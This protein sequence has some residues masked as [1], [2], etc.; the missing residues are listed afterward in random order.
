MTT[1]SGP[2]NGLGQLHGIL[3][4]LAASLTFS[5]LDMQAKYLTQTQSVVQISWARYFGHFVVMMVF[6]WPKYG[7]RLLVTKRPVMQF[8]R[9]ILLLLCT[10]M[11]F[12][13]VSLM[14]LADAVAI[15]FASPMLAT[16]LSVPLLKE[17]VG[18]RRWIA[19]LVGFIAVLIIIRPGSGVMSWA[20]LLVIGVAFFFSLF[21]L[22]TRMM[23][24]TEDPKVT[25][26]FSAVVGAVALTCVVP[27]YWV[28]PPSWKETMMLAGL[29]LFGGLGHYLLIKAYQYAP[30][31]V[32]SPLSYSSL[33][34]ATTFG[35]F[36]FND[37]P[38][39]WT[40]VGATVLIATGIYI[41]YREGIR[42]QSS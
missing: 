13:A 21:Q 38:D 27:F 7:H 14:P 17:K 6:L 39:Q 5:M 32:L 41:L 37:F 12:T 30:V 25:L 31:A 18:A 19:V 2:D 36:V 15:S 40:L 33:I 23:A 28:Q 10:F 29:G 34:W 8:V 1:S 20:A 16:A 26:F 42:G 3:L 9:S 4:M 35:Y 22:M 24:H 11:F